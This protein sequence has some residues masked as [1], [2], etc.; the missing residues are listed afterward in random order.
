MLTN[1]R[2]DLIPSQA[3]RNRLPCAFTTDFIH[4]YDHTSGEVIFRPRDNPWSTDTDVWRLKRGNSIGSWHLVKGSNVLVNMTSKSARMFS[5]AVHTI[6]EAQHVH[7]VLDT[8]TRVVDIDIPR[9]QLAFYAEHADDS[10]HSRQFRGMIIDG[11]QNIGSLV[12]LTSKLVLKREQSERMILIPVPQE[13]NRTSITCAWLSV[14]Q[15]VAVSI[16]KE[17][18]T[19]VYAYTLDEDLGRIVDSGDLESKLLIA[20]LHAITSSCLPD[21][22]TKLTG[23][24]A[25][26]ELLQS[27]AVRSFDILTPRN[28]DLLAQLARLSTKRSFYPSHERVMQSVGWDVN[29][30]SLS[31]HPCFRQIVN[32]IF[33]HATDMQLFFPGD[34][35]FRSIT[36]AQRRLSSGTYAVTKWPRY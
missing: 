30:P 7:I 17:E 13:F 4:W 29:L 26:L 16:N 15:H 1:E 27:A 3:F 10:L 28:V 36:D 22:L 9:L 6:E 21:P 31:Q 18:A 23:T 32:D 19:K 8:T 12:G 20:Y 14:T 24:E 2:L 33:K 11:D 34:G 25:S 5:K 35:V